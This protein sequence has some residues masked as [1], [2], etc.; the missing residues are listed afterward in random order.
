MS[1]IQ[2]MSDVQAEIMRSCWPG[3]VS[4]V[5]LR[6]CHL[7]GFILDCRKAAH[8]EVKFDDVVEFSHILCTECFDKGV[9]AQID[10]GTFRANVAAK[11]GK[12]LWDAPSDTRTLPMFA[13][14]DP[15]AQPAGT[16]RVDVE[17]IDGR[18]VMGG[19]R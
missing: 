18:V 19:A 5:A 6:G 12:S 16:V 10:E 4:Q 15:A 7:C 8:V 11:A 2:F 17:I 14:I 13:G 9:A 1:H 3:M